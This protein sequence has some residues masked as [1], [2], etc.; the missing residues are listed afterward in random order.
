MNRNDFLSSLGALSIMPSVVKN[1]QQSANPG[2]RKEYWE[3]VRRDFHI[4]DKYID[5]RAHA[6]SPIPRTTLKSI[7]ATYSSIQA[8]PSHRNHEVREGDKE[9]L[10]KR[11]AEEINCSVGEVALMRSTTEALNNVIMGFQF[12]AGDEVLASVHEYDSMIGSLYQRQVRDGITIKQVEIPY[13]PDSKEQIIDLYKRAATPRTKMILISHIV[14]ISGQIYPIEEICT[15]ARSRGIITVID[16]AQSFAHIPVDVSRIGCD[17]LGAPLHKWCAA[18]I[19]TGFLYVKKGHIPSTYPLFGHYGYKPDDSHIEKFENFGALMPVFDACN[20]SI[21]YWRKI[22]FEVKM[23]RMRYLTNYWVDKIE[24]LKGVRIC[25]N[26]NQLDSCGIACFTVEGRSSTEL[27]K[28]LFDTYKI[29]VHSTEG[30][31]ND[32]VD[33][34]DVNVIG[35]ATPVF[36]LPLHLDRF[37]TALKEIIK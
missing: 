4:D 15:W 3:N 13:Q 27:R 23:K 11:L 29:S 26:V 17:Y 10:R 5:L 33:Y 24:P 18:P 25:T 7:T 19:G 14:W 8:F 37:V 32:L 2:M 35:V 16:A 9:P 34:K 31:K 21:D 28:Q 22:G 36:I 20:D 6:L 30:Y 1:I 12:K